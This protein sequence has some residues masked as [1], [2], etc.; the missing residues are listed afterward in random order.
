MVLL[1]VLEMRQRPG[2]GSLSNH[3]PWWSRWKINS[4]SMGTFFPQQTD[5]WQRGDGIEFSNISLCT[6]T[7]TTSTEPI[8]HRNGLLGTYSNLRSDAL[9]H[10]YNRQL[11]SEHFSFKRTPRNFGVH[12]LNSS[13]ERLTFRI[14]WT[15]PQY[16]QSKTSLVCSQYES[17]QVRSL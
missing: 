8:N 6:T 1:I 5:L 3:K 11:S 10:T 16:V 13:F 7:D 2:K 17:H 4:G 14:N 12:F 15:F 9:R